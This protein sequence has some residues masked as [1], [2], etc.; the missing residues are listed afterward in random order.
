M[1]CFYKGIKIFLTLLLTSS[2]QGSQLFFN[3]I[4][5][6]K[7]FFFSSHV[8]VAQNF[9]PTVKKQTKI[10]LSLIHLSK[11]LPRLVLTLH[12]SWKKLDSYVIDISCCYLLNNRSF[13]FG[14]CSRKEWTGRNGQL[15]PPKGRV[16]HVPGPEFNS[17][18]NNNNKNHLEEKIV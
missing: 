4:P 15:K 13:I 6:T 8:T 11:I 9:K 12:Q 2:G 17:Q 16:R 10:S 5:T 18:N 7:R 3:L 14:H 1:C